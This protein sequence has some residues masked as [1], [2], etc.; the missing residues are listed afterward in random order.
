MSEHPSPATEREPDLNN[1]MVRTGG[2]MFYCQC[3]G[4]VFH[5]ESKDSMVYICNSCETCYRGEA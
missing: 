3:G 5:K 2:K 1:I 4:N